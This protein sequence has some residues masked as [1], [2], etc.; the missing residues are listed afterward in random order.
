MIET[1]NLFL[2]EFRQ[3]MTNHPKRRVRA[4]R[5]ILFHC[6]RLTEGESLLL[7]FNTETEHI[8]CDIAQVA[9]HW[10]HNVDID[11]IPNL[12]MH[13]A[14]RPAKTA[15]KIANSSL[16]ICLTLMSLVYTKARRN[17]GEIGS[18]FLR[19][20]DFDNGILMPDTL[21]T[22]YHQQFKVVRV[23]NTRY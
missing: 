13:G 9:Q 22:D 7:I 18:R 8:A 16:I 5:H 17:F 12:S 10:S 15:K 1:G 14:E 20:P 23:S 6:G 11:A 4:I 2:T 21:M 19:L 3:S